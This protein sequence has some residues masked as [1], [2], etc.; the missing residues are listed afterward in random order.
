MLHCHKEKSLPG[1]P[2]YLQDVPGVQT[3]PILVL[4][5]HAHHQEVPMC[6]FML[7]PL[8]GVLFPPSQVGETL[9]ILGAQLKC[10]LLYKAFLHLSWHITP[11]SDR[12]HC[13]ELCWYQQ[14][15]N[16]QCQ[17]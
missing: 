4:L 12:K 8:S 6:S 5:I 16:I 11:S 10:C 7:S 9:P 13:A 14:H 15:P 1:L 3:L 2:H 17:T